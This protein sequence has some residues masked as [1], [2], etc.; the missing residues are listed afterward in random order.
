MYELRPY[1]KQAVDN[2]IK[3]FKKSK[4]PA[5]LVLPTGAGKSIIIAELAKLAKG[6]VL[7]LTHVKELVEQ[8]H[9][10]YISLDLQAGIFSAGLKKKQWEEKVIFAGI[11][12]LVNAPD[13]VFENYSIVIIDECHRVDMEG[14]TQYSKVINQLIQKNPKLC[15]L[16]TT[17][18]PYRHGQG[19]IY[20]FH[21]KGE[22][23]SGHER[24]FKK[25][26]FELSL[27]FLIKN[28][29]LTPPIL[30]DSPVACYNFE[31]L[32][33]NSQGKFNFNRVE[34][35]LQEQKRVT[36]LIVHNICDMAKERKGV[37][38][39]TSTIRHAKEVL[40][41]LED[42]NSAI[43]T[44]ETDAKERDRLIREFKDQKIKF[45]VN[46]SVLTTGFDAPHVDLIA[47]LRPTESQGLF[48]QIIGRGLRLSPN[49]EDCLVLDYTGLGHNL[50][51]PEIDNK[52]PSS[53]SVPVKVKCPQCLFE[54]DFWGLVDDQGIIMEHFGRKCRGAKENVHKEN[55][56]IKCGYRFRYK[57]CPSCASENDISARE[58]KGCSSVLVDTDKKLKEAMSLKDC[59]ILHPDT[60][61]LEA[62]FD[63][64][65]K[66]RLEIRYYDLDAEYLSEYFYF[67][68]DNADKI[69]FYNFIRMHHKTPEKKL[70]IKNIQQAIDSQD[71]FRMPKY[72]IAQKKKYF[73]QIRE[74]I[75]IE[76]T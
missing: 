35:L 58:C 33:K 23:K 18:T 43:I 76:S 27:S 37:M 28:K 22:I 26:I 56:I 55:E 60:M 11:Q 25:C 52:K 31:N 36:P 9:Q 20:E 38:I 46:V 44:G 7:V 59:H 34:D 15:I 40:G 3:H 50:F 29:Y 10:K 1:Q 53:D 45:L 14:D 19:W 67:D 32:E 48:Q 6:R 70:I 54:N 41:L 74:K 42:K 65:G 51:S 71:K 17:A 72:V 61:T 57:I 2:T 69:F 12:S 64:K 39:F 13:E 73:W 30:I 63:K 47:L 66:E 68:Q 8:N 16:G 49:K 62:S 21:Y 5:V 4:S 75:F 24:F